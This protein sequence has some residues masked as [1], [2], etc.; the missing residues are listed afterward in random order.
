VDPSSLLLDPMPTSSG[1]VSVTFPLFLL[2]LLGFF[3]LLEHAH[4]SAA[5]QRRGA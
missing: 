1:G 4:A 2:A 5:F 3:L